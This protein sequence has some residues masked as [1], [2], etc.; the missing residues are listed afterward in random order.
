MTPLALLA[1]ALAAPV[2]KEFANPRDYFPTA[3]GSKWEY[4]SSGVGED[5][6]H[7]EEITAAD[8]KDGEL[9]VTFRRVRPEVKDGFDTVYTVGKKDIS[10]AKSGPLVYDPPLPTLRKGMKIGDNWEVETSISGRK[11]T[12]EFKVGEA[13]EVKTPAGKFLAVPVTRKTKG[14]KLA[15]YT[16][17]YAPD[18]GL[19]KTDAGQ[20]TTVLTKFTIGK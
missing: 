15:G 12:F 10:L 7:S 14:S 3:V 8:E 5:R 9:R 17:W 1:V 6:T 16:L 4:V 18:V 2:P 20:V 11:T 19:V 13:A